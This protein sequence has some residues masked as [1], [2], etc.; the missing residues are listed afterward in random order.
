M[1]LD[2][3][4]SAWR[5]AVGFVHVAAK[6]GGDGGNG[7]HGISRIAAIAKIG[8]CNRALLERMFRARFNDS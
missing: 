1:F 5:S 4:I 3:K 7:V 8:N 6:V 2:E